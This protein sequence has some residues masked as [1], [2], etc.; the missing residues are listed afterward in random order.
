MRK[1]I[2]ILIRVGISAG[3]LFFLSKQVDLDK[4]FQIA[5]G[6]NKPILIFAF[7]LIVI[8]YVV[9]F[10][11]WK[12][13]LTG[14]GLDLDLFLIF[15][16]F[17]LGSFSNLFFPSTIGG[18]LIRSIDLGLRTQKPKW[19][20]ASVILDRISGY[21][22]LVAVGSLALLFGHKLVADRLVFIA[23][24]IILVLLTGCLGIL[25]NNFLFSKSTKLLRIFGRLGEALSRL[26][27][28][29][30][31]FRN[32]KR[33]ILRNFLFSLIIQIIITISFYLISLALGTRINPI[34]FFIF[35]PII[36]T[37]S[38]LPISIAGLG[39]R[40]ASSMYFFIRVGMSREVA[41]A[42]AFLNFL[43]IFLVGLSGGIIYVFTFSHRRLQRNQT[44]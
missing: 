29:I 40:E 2:S 17:C 16:S 33:I 22:A 10:F 42:V 39:L 44:N 9:A 41:L 37:I 43:M 8:I 1:T 20:V 24:G 7:L 5:S 27:Y 30:Y 6:I 25:F 19:V 12:M 34:Y 31:N 11:R 4:I 14:L 35:V 38:A 21:C 3:I 36:A 26:H 15:R 18:D 23:M 28:A 32:Q 13:L